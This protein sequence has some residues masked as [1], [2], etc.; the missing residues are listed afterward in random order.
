MEREANYVAVGAFVLLITAMAVLFVYWYSDTRDQRSFTRYEVYFDGSVGGLAIGSQVRYLGVDVGRVVRIRLDPRAA[1]RVQVIVDIDA[2]AP[3]SARTLAQLATQGVTGLLN[4]DLLLQREDVPTEGLMD[5]VPG[6]HYPVIRSV[7]SNIDVFLRGLPVV[8]SQ[9]GELAERSN[10]LLADNNIAALSRLVANLDRAGAKLPQAASEA[11]ELIAE[12][13]ATTAASRQLIGD[14]QKAS[15][16]AGPDLDATLAKLRVAAGNLASA[17]AQL[18]GM[19]ADDRGAL[20]GFAQ[21]GLPQ[22]EALVRD[23]RG[24]AREL[25][26]L[27]RSLR[28]NPSQLLYQPPSAAVEIPR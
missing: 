6:E 18:D 28:E 23:S 10:K 8:A 12:L 7:R 11:G 19:L 22:F 21:Q 20:H 16:S 15:A 9:I 2:S 14:L 25:Q 17:S 3:I 27:A 5:P 24:A 1:S 13:R 4:I 26:Q